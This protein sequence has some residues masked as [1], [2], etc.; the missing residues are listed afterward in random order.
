VRTTFATGPQGRLPLISGLG[1]A[2]VHVDLELGGLGQ[3]PEQSRELSPLLIAERSSDVDFVRF[4]NLA[5]PGK[6]KAALFSEI[7][8]VVATIS[9]AAFA[10]DEPERFQTVN[11]SDDSALNRSELVCEITLADARAPPKDPKHARLRRRNTQRPGAHSEPGC[12]VGTQLR[13]QKA[14][15][16]GTWGLGHRNRL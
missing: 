8:F 13:K 3:Y 5:Q 6:Q 1:E 2:G 11:Q 9:R 12:R 7:Q 15:A 16:C 10:H 14:D 4:G